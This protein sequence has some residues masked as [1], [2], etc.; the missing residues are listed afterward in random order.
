MSLENTKQSYSPDGYD[1]VREHYGV[2]VEIGQRVVIDGTPGVIVRGADDQYLHFVPDGKRLR[3][4]A[5]PTWRVEY[6]SCS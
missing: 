5:H 4:I 2:Q 6:G 1:Y 3:L